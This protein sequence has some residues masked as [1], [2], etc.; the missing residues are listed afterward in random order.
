MHSSP[1]IR[2]VA[3]GLFAFAFRSTSAQQKDTL[4]LT[5]QAAVTQA[6]PASDEI[7][8]SQA[9]K[10]PPAPQAGPARAAGLPQPR[11]TSTYTHAYENA[12]A[13][14]VGQVFNQP[15]TYNT[16]LNFSQAVF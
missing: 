14:A 4:R 8:T 15:N 16:S 12:R 2:T 6:L 13:Q 1:L 10:D 5:I 7:R 9:Q 3:F 11:L